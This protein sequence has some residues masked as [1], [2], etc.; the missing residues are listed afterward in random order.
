[1]EN[2]FV[3]ILHL[4][5]D[6]RTSLNHSSPEDD[7][8]QLVSSDPLFRFSKMTFRRQQITRVV[9][10]ADLPNSLLSNISANFRKIRNGPNRILRGPGETDS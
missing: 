10:S 2:I 8:R 5:L 1:M 4:V 3:L 9:D 7:F 6:E